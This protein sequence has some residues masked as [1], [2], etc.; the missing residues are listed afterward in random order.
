MVEIVEKLKSDRLVGAIPRCIP[1][2]VSELLVA[3]G[4][5]IFYHFPLLFFQIFLLDKM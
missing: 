1:I 5:L 3:P 2:R 4:G